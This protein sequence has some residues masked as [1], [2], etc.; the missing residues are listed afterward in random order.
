MRKLSL[1]ENPLLD[2]NLLLLKTL[3]PETSLV[4]PRSRRRRGI[5]Y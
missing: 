2:E 1:D 5:C 3:L 4:I